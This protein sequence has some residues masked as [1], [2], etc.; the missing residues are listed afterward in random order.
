VSVKY[1][2]LF[3]D[4]VDVDAE[5]QVRRDSSPVITLRPYQ[6]EAVEAV[7]REWEGVQSTLVCQPT[8]TG[9]S[10]VFTEVMRRWLEE[11]K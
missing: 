2:S 10:I 11:N 6:L 1:M 8:G 9:K 7:Y 3:D 5:I 4:D